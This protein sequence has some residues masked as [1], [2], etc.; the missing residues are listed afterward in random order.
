MA[1]E[2]EMTKHEYICQIVETVANK[3]SCNKRKVGAIFINDE[4]EILA[5]GYNQSPKG[6]PN[7][8]NNN[9]FINQKCFNTIHAEQNAIVQAAKRGVALKNSSI[10]VTLFP[11]IECCKLLINLNIKNIIYKEISS[12]NGLSMIKYSKI[13]AIKW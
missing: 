4:Y 10:Y 9:C 11:C 7:C 1:S 6:F 13:K 12:S 8:N 5:T 2:Q 3:S